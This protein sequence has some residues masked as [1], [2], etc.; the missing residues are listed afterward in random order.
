MKSRDHSV[1]R[2][3]L[4]S[5]SLRI[6]TSTL[7]TQI[8]TSSRHD[9]S[10]NIATDQQVISHQPQL[11]EGAV[12]PGADLL[13]A[14][15]LHREHRALS[16]RLT[17]VET[18]AAKQKEQIAAAEQNAH[19]QQ[20]G[21]V[22]ALTERLRKL[23]DADASEQVAGLAAELRATRQQLEQAREKV[24]LIEKAKKDNDG[25]NED[26]D[27]DVQIK[28]EEFASVVAQMH[29]AMQS[30][31]GRLDVAGD[32]AARTATNAVAASTERHEEQIRALSEQLRSL[33]RAQGD[34]RALLVS[35]HLHIATPA[36]PV[37][38]GPQVPK[39][40]ETARTSS[41]PSETLSRNDQLQSGPQAMIGSPAQEQTGTGMLVPQQSSKVIPSAT[42]TVGATKKRKPSAPD[43]SKRKRGFTKEITQLIH[44]DGSLTNAPDTLDRQEPSITT[45]S[46]KR[47]K[48][49]AVGGM[50]LR[51]A[52]P[53]PS[54]SAV[55]TKEEL[56]ST[57]AKVLAPSARP[58]A[59]KMVTEHSAPDAAMIKTQG[60]KGRSR[61]KKALV[62]RKP[63][64]S[65]SDEIHVFHNPSALVASP[66]SS[67][68]KKSTAIQQ[69]QRPQQRRRRIEQDD[70][71]EEFLA[72][73]E[74]ATEM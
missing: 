50:S 14:F 30:L 62:P 65:T 71:M 67:K 28:L 38:A 35:R 23:E 44:G 37:Q 46:S 42:Q 32:S 22:N 69:E 19:S 58:K 52:L 7:H 34:L 57:R 3:S 1:V 9:K 41:N 11:M 36:L 64:L 61:P 25:K 59:A 47:L 48:A 49:G 72:K 8:T 5:T 43:T 63:L 73:C 27:R 13:W 45:R 51:S 6:L 54:V 10:N 2:A 55:K 17:A 66:Q 68:L 26:R 4:N 40:T 53:Q 74:A 18:S 21:R 60:K 20:H 12:K 31:E 15:Q 29:N 24:K 70:S 39:S 33:E 56:V 16:K